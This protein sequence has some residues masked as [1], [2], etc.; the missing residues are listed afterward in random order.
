M[1]KA[2]ANKKLIIAGLPE[3]SDAEQFWEKMRHKMSVSGFDAL[4]EL[5]R[6]KNMLFGKAEVVN[7]LGEVEITTDPK[8][9]N[10]VAT[11]QWKSYFQNFLELGDGIGKFL[12]EAK[13]RPQEPD[14]T[15]FT[16]DELRKGIKSLKTGKM[17]G[18]DWLPA[19]V[20]KELLDE[21]E[22]PSAALELLLLTMNCWWEYG[23]PPEVQRG[24]TILLYKDGAR[25]NPLNYR[26]IT[27]LNSVYKL[28]TMLLKRRLEHYVESKDILVR[29][30]AGFQA[31]RGTHEHISSLIGLAELQKQRKKKFIALYVDLVKAY[32]SVQFE[33]VVRTLRFYGVPE[34]LVRAIELTLRNRQT[35]IKTENATSEPIEVTC[36]VAQGDVISPLLF[37]LVLN[38]LLEVLES[39]AQQGVSSGQEVNDGNP[40]EV[41]P[42]RGIPLTHMKKRIPV[43]AYADDIVLLSDNWEDMVVLFS[44]VKLF[45]KEARLNISPS[46]SGIHVKDWASQYEEV[47][48][49]LYVTDD[50]SAQ[51]EE[52]KVRYYKPKES[53][54]YLGILFNPELC[55]SAHFKKLDTSV[56]KTWRSVWKDDL[57]S[58]AAVVVANAVIA[59]LVSYSAKVLKINKTNLVKWDR[60]SRK[61]V[62]R[63][64][65]NRFWNF[66]NLFL[67]QPKVEGGRGLVNIEELARSEFMGYNVQMGLS[68]QGLPHDVFMEQVC[69]V[70][71]RCGGRFQVLRSTGDPHLA[72][73]YGQE[74]CA[75]KRLQ[76]LFDECSGPE[77]VATLHFAPQ[78]DYI[79]PVEF[80][81]RRAHAM[82]NEVR[83]ALFY[84]NMDL[85]VRS[86]DRQLEE[87]QDTVSDLPKR[88][89]SVPEF[90]VLHGITRYRQLMRNGRVI[91]EQEFFTKFVRAPMVSTFNG[92]GKFVYDPHGLLRN[93]NCLIGAIRTPEQN[94]YNTRI[95]LPLTRPESKWYYDHVRKMVENYT[96]KHGDNGLFSPRLHQDFNFDSP[97]AKV[98]V[99]TDGSYGPVDGEIRGAAAFDACI[100]LE[101]GTKHKFQ[102]V[103]DLSHH[104]LTGSYDTELYEIWHVL[105]MF[106]VRDL[107][108]VTDSLS[109]IEFIKKQRSS[110][111][112]YFNYK[113]IALAMQI[114]R[115]MAVR[116]RI[117]WHTELRHIYSHQE[118]KM[119]ERPWYWGPRIARQRALY[120]PEEWLLA[121]SGNAWA[122]LTANAVRA[123][124]YQ[125]PLQVRRGM[126]AP[127][128]SVPQA[129]L[130]SRHREDP[131][132]HMGSRIRQFFARKIGEPLRATGGV[133]LKTN[134]QGENLRGEVARHTAN[135]F[136]LEVISLTQTTLSKLQIGAVISLEPT[137]APKWQV[138]FGDGLCKLCDAG[139]P[140]TLEHVLM[141]CRALAAHRA[142]CRTAAHQA[143]L[144]LIRL[145]P[146]TPNIF[147]R[148]VNFV[149]PF[150]GAAEESWGDKANKA[151]Q[152]IA[153]SGPVM[154]SLLGCVPRAF[155][156]W[157]ECTAQALGQT[158]QERFEG[159]ERLEKLRWKIAECGFKVSVALLLQRQLVLK[160][161]QER[162]W[163]ENGLNQTE[164]QD[165][166]VESPPPMSS[167]ALTEVAEAENAVLLYKE[168]LAKKKAE[169]AREFERIKGLR[170]VSKT[171][172]VRHILERR[173]NEEREGVT[174]V[175]PLTVIRR[176]TESTAASSGTRAEV[177][178]RP[179]PVIARDRNP[180]AQPGQRGFGLVNLGNTCYLNASLQALFAMPGVDRWL[181]TVSPDEGQRPAVTALRRI[182][183]ELK[184]RTTNPW[185][186]KAEMGNHNV[187]FQGNDQ[188]D[189]Q[190]LVALLLDRL[191][192]EMDN[193]NKPLDPPSSLLRGE[194]AERV[195]CRGCETPG[196][197][198]QVFWT[199]PL[200]IAPEVTSIQEAM[201]AQIGTEEVVELNCE[202]CASNEAVKRDHLVEIR[203]GMLIQV[204]RFE[205]NIDNMGQAACVKT[206]A[207]LVANESIQLQAETGG[208][209]TLRLRAIVVHR[210]NSPLA[211]HY[212]AYVQN[213]GS[214][215]TESRQ[216]ELFDDANV[217]TVRQDTVFSQEGEVS[218]DSYLLLYEKA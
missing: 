113:N 126:Q 76:H 88:W 9:V 38:P 161:V 30:Q 52:N 136:I 193:T 211:G 177:R 43:L 183:E 71:S 46:K 147:E 118:D 37:V 19:E 212:V 176:D 180:S 133:A 63:R 3:K 117:G 188:Q 196:G 92:G 86:A 34:N 2:Q 12:P 168:G 32:D 87:R 33:L 213:R 74:V 97:I 124:D 197:Q 111:V 215:L 134:W 25:T 40:E 108:I 216:W 145:G 140:E 102:G 14:Q 51:T 209:T 62:K 27:M 160:R 174:N 39:N 65:A 184:L 178:A 195:T 96:S 89:A 61:E 99:M 90:L 109:S 164:S 123:R 24:E 166:E 217:S 58:E 214:E 143:M 190:E 210:G 203:E 18:Q 154:D 59:G 105:R 200:T 198:Q 64:Y 29:S 28:Y 1:K 100:M 204:K 152:L 127:W 131:V 57:S 175:A 199:L 55:W 206:R 122:D 69:R 68:T 103:Q 78:E 162:L 47:W 45:C 5:K 83:Q 104:E 119:E 79:K 54:K 67:Y 75:F 112:E 128:P 110:K 101:D 159:V 120:T 16:L 185:D 20:W 187:C 26:P 98:Q 36:G 208:L 49:D 93:G 11:G 91:S 23:P 121:K 10:E 144:R 48:P 8:V 114:R 205:W 35:C 77:A 207:P 194:L 137:L 191:G 53:Y 44:V 21:G 186:L 13:R 135:S 81:Y 192:V 107:L 202:N 42:Q 73:W 132:R 80:A 169:N 139:R 138:V 4:K 85:K 182:R 156:K 150:P 22:E 218:R 141:D 163:E 153:A 149:L 172:M 31:N 94:N 6:R 95:L 201:D 50:P 15:H 130:V 115:M 70:E 155:L 158:D 7:E 171:D 170:V 142:R 146:A 82:V 17:P 167:S 179:R 66:N 173:H 84:W 60:Q 106:P 41:T 56:M 157:A 151:A 181:D 148:T 129:L 165:M 125:G 116:E 72:R 189:A